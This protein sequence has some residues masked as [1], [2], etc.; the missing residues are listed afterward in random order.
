MEEWEGDQR[1]MA[2]GHEGPRLGGPCGHS[3]ARTAEFG[4][5]LMIHGS[6]CSTA[7]PK[8]P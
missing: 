6:G 4:P 8:S 2:R 3:G 7:H 5:A 1:T